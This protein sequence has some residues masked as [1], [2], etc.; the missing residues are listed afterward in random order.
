M[1]HQLGFT[2]FLNQHFAGV[3]NGVLGAFHYHVEN[4]AAPITNSFS[5]EVLLMG[6]LLAAFLLVR[7]NLSVENPGAV[8]HLA[9][10]YYNFIDDQGAQI[11][12]HGHQRYMPFIGALCL[13]IL[14]SNLIGLVP[15][16]ESPTG[17]LVVPLGCAITV[18]CYYNWL[19]IREQ[20]IVGYI[21]HFMGPVWWLAP[22]LFPIEI[23]SHLARML[24]L[25]VRLYANMLAGDLLI[26]VFFSLFPIGLPIV[27]LGLHLGVALIQAYLFT[28]LAIIYIS[29][30]VSHDAEAAH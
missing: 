27:F 11:I 22:L 9:E 26:L 20:G 7:A 19:G 4:P 15:G 13:F 24:S 2:A 21:K 16:F 14:I 25:T 8:Q 6:I 29:Q 18:F 3:A 10:S 23:I 12:E 28:V 1:E 30:A 17:F 5:M